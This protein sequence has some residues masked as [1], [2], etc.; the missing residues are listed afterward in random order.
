MPLPFILAG[1]AVVSGVWGAKSTYDAKQTNDQ[2]ED[3]RKKAIKIFDKAKNKLELN[4]E[5]TNESLEVLGKLKMIVWDEELKSFIETFKKIKNVSLQG[6]PKMDQIDDISFQGEQLHEIENTAMQYSKIVGS[7]FSGLAAGAT[8]GVAAYGGA[9]ALGT[10][11]TGTAI[12]TLTG[13]AASKATLAWLGGGALSA[14][15]YGV[16]GGT[17]V[18]GGIVLGPALLAG[19]F[20][21]SRKADENLSRA[22]SDLAL[23]NE[24]AEEI[25]NL[26]AVLKGIRK[27]SNLYETAIDRFRNHFKDVIHKLASLVDNQGNNFAEYSETDQKLVHTSILFAEVQKK[28]LETPLL[29]ENGA[30]RKGASDILNMA[31]RFLAKN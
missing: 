20:F 9:M 25:K 18:L 24:K 2:A 13:A 30:V 17:A 27:I 26:I 4:R 3:T 22:R 1:A 7:G 6:I 12:G 15:G 14:G 31:D 28:L 21:L 29:D 11:S 5:E 10:A 19:G 8:T 16:A 23:A